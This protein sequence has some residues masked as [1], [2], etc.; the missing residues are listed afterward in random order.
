[1]SA[2]PRTHYIDREPDEY[3]QFQLPKKPKLQADFSSQLVS[4][5]FTP[6]ASP[7]PYSFQTEIDEHIQAY[8]SVNGADL[9]GSR[10]LHNY[11][12]RISV[13]PLGVFQYLIEQKG[14][15]INLYDEVKKTPLHY[16][17]SLRKTAYQDNTLLYLLHRPDVDLYSRNSQNRTLLHLLCYNI[18]H[19]PISVFSSV[20]GS[21]LHRNNNNPNTEINLTVQDDYKDTPLHDAFHN[22]DPLN[23]DIL[24]YL[25]KNTKYDVN[26]QNNHGETILHKAC[27]RINDLTLPVFKC[28]IEGT[29]ANLNIK[30]R[31]GAT[32]LSIALLNIS[33]N[34]K[35]INTVSYLLNQDGINYNQKNSRGRSLLQSACCNINDL[36]LSIFEQLIE[37]KGVDFSIQDEAH[38][39]ALHLAFFNFNRSSDINILF[40]LLKQNGVDFNQRGQYRFTVLHYAC[41]RIEELP[42]EMFKYLL[43]ETNLNIN[44]WDQYEQSPLSI[45]LFRFRDLNSLDILRYLLSHKDVNIHQKTQIGESLLHQACRNKNNIPLEIFTYLIETLN[46]DIYAEDN[47]QLTPFHILLRGLVW[48]LPT[49]E[50]DIYLL[51]RFGITDEFNN[52]VF[53]QLSELR[54]NQYAFTTFLLDNKMIKTKTDAGKYFTWLCCQTRFDP[55]LI[56]FF[57]QNFNCGGWCQSKCSY[58][59]VIIR[60][61]GVEDPFLEKERD[62]N[63][64]LMIAHLLEEEIVVLSGPLTQ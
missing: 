17:L 47:R 16:A 41:E 45:A 35:N 32:A 10:L 21:K 61:K 18:A 23:T 7:I 28:L 31:N 29:G 49:T 50:I 42:L 39:N 60:K 43:E 40:Y 14:A 25:L 27:E 8:G 57:Y 54:H 2:N 4:L 19:L 30:D 3:S 37:G 38:D 36:P 62:E 33:S 5:H 59:H 12:Q 58:L 24:L 9:S 13:T 11:C 64:A 1:M 44:E 53:S 20:I 56:K 48:G 22:F 55:D 34:S 6:T 46:V 15:D 63:I 52:D 51:S 26:L